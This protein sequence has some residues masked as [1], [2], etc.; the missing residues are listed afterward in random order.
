MAETIGIAMMIALLLLMMRPTFFCISGKSPLARQFASLTTRLICV[1]VRLRKLQRKS[2]HLRNATVN[3]CLVPNRWRNVR[4]ECALN[5]L[6][7]RPHCKSRMANRCSVLC[8]IPAVRVRKNRFALYPEKSLQNYSSP[9]LFCIAHGLHSPSH[10][11]S[12]QA[13]R[14]RDFA[15]PFNRAVSHAAKRRCAMQS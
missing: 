10:L 2:R 9:P 12:I 7:L 15:D 1:P 8:I 6:V 3:R 11:P 14:V 4:Q 5:I 13:L